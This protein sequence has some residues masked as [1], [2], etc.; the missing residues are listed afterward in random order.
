M[1]LYLVYARLSSEN[2][3]EMQVASLG[4]LCTFKEQTAS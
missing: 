4:V 2:S 1:Y 3:V